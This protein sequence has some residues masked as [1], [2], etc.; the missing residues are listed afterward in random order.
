M[1]DVIEVCCV[2]VAI[3]NRRC[4][5]PIVQTYPLPLCSR[6][7]ERVRLFFVEQYLEQRAVD[8]V[9]AQAAP[10]GHV[11]FAQ[12]VEA[13]DRVKIGFSTCVAARMRHLR[14]VPIVT[15]PG[16]IQD[17]TALH[18]RFAHLRAPGPGAHVRSTEWFWLQVEIRRHIESLDAGVDEAG[19]S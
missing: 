5:R 15:I 7:Y 2:P 18:K 19:A 11:Y 13:P 14:L 9:A 8:L 3:Y 16:A 6:H 1:S 17:E 4:H 10:D 12:D